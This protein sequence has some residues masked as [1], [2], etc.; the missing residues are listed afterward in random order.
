MGREIEMRGTTV[1]AV[2]REGTTAV[3]GDGQVTL[4]NTVMKQGAKKVR[5]IY[6]GNV[7]VGFAGATADAITLYERL[8]QKLQEY[9][10]NLTRAAVEM[11]KEWRTDKVLR[12]LEAL[13]IAV[14]KEHLF[15]ISGSGDV[16]EPDDGLAGIGSGGP[17]ALAA[18]RA[19]V[20]NSEMSA[21]EIA[22]RSLKIASEICI[23]T[24][25]SITVEEV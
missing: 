9:S 12:R 6:N 13:M 1:I 25:D 15:L 11:A 18:G 8:E 19:L 7:V 23:Y 10:G 14:D 4:G 16:L 22:L 17:Y 21:G 24:N 20:R 3:A 5:R 2:R